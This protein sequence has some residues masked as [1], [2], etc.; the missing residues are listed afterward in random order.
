MLSDKRG[1]GVY[2]ASF[3]K[4]S[5]RVRLADTDTNAVYGEG[6]DHTGYLLWLRGGSL[7]AQQFDADTPRLTGSPHPVAD[8]YLRSAVLAK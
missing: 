8:P 1:N 4:P 5:E 2:A 7:V 3:A 6:E